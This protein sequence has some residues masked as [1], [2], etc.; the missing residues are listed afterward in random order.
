VSGAGGD[1]TSDAS[2]DEQTGSEQE[3]SGTT[4]KTTEATTLRLIFGR[5][6]VGEIVL[7]HRKPPQVRPHGG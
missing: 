7:M 3:R 6:N 2:A 4:P 1:E 5:E